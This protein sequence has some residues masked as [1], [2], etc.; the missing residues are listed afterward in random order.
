MNIIDIEIWIPLTTKSFK[1]YVS[2][3]DTLDVNDLKLVEHIISANGE[4]GK[5]M[6]KKR[7]M[8]VF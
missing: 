8:L 6:N 2:Q 1:L 4:K 3:S 5:R 7:K